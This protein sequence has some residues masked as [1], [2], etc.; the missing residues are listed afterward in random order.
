[1]LILE[2]HELDGY[3][4]EEVK[5]PKRDEENAKYNKDM[6]ESYRIITDSIKDHLIP[7]VSSNNTPKERFDALTSLFEGKNIDIRM[8][9]RNQ[10]KAVKIQKE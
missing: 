4:K 7:Q 3:I 8:N 10:L 6:I 9:L 2:E 1:M 5:E